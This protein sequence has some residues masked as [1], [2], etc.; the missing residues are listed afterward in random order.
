MLA[1]KVTK[2]DEKCILMSFS[3]RC[4]ELMFV[5]KIENIEW[6]LKVETNESKGALMV[7]LEPLFIHQKTSG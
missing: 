2:Y 6:M 4:E 3:G 7:R 1:K 5:V